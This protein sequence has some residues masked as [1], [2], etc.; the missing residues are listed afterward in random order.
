MLIKKISVYVLLFHLAA[1][2]SSDLVAQKMT[3]ASYNIRYDN[4]RDT[5]NL[6]QD[7]KHAVTA[8][9]RYHNFDVLGV[10]EALKHQLQDLSGA[11]KGYAVYGKGRD[12]GQ[13]K[14]EHSSIYY[15]K[16]KFELVASGDFWLSATPEK[17]GPGW[18]A[19]LNRICTWVHLKEKKSG[20]TFY[21]FNAHYDHQG[22]QARIESSK[23]VLTTIKEIAG[24]APAIF[25]GDLNGN[26]E[27]EWYRSLSGSALLRDSYNL[28]RQPH[29]PNGSTNGFRTTGVSK[30]VIDHIFI[31][32]QF[33]VKKWA[34]LTDTYLGRF[35]SDHF[36]VAANLV[37]Q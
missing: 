13:S 31:S 34:V 22:I 17:P 18:D 21:V 32:K 27:S 35:P 24:E 26:R 25:M 9:I 14:G 16:A 3:V 4:P 7:R 15:K 33:T 1:L 10:Q 23:L 11:L 12:D 2:F 28:A 6:W 37:L 20:K 36:P 8:L 29:Q 19:N 30:D 5:G